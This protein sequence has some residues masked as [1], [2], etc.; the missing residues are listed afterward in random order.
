MTLSEITTHHPTGLEVIEGMAPNRTDHRKEYFGTGKYYTV[1]KQ[2]KKIQKTRNFLWNT[3][4][5]VH[6]F[7]LH[8]L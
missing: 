8:F 7:Q 2:N 1:P 4:F 3:L 5:L 6:S